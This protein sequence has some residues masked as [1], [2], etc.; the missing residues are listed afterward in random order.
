[1]SVWVH[2][3]PK[4]NLSQRNISENISE[5]IPEKIHE[6]FMRKFLFVSGLNDVAV[7]RLRDR[8]SWGISVPGDPDH[9][10]G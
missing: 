8:L 6:K 4:Q 5:K 3:I 7:S 2:L 10:V 9:V 1:M